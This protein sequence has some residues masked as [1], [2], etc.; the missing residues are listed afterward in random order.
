[1]LFHSKSKQALF[2]NLQT[3]GFATE[4][5]DIESPICRYFNLIGCLPFVPAQSVQEIWSYLWVT[6]HIATM[7][8]AIKSMSLYSQIVRVMDHIATVS[9]MSLKAVSLYSP[10][11]DL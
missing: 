1:M 2:R 3:S 8:E 7:N 10:R 11:T 4:Y 6:D 9:E 5:N